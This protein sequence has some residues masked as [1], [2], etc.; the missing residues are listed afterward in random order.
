MRWR[1]A[2]ETVAPGNG[3]ERLRDAHLPRKHLHSTGWPSASATIARAYTSSLRSA[4]GSVIAIEMAFA[5]L[6]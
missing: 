3:S 2:I 5:L 1:L 4:V 6:S